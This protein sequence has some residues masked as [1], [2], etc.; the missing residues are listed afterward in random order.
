M[1]IIYGGI[2]MMTSGGEQQKYASAKAV[3]TNGLLGLIIVFT[4]YWIVT[5]VGYALGISTFGNVFRIN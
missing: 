3:M 2:M 5:I 1:Y 4:S